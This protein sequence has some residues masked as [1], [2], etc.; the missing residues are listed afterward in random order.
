MY[1]VDNVLQIYVQWGTVVNPWQKPPER[2]KTLT[3]NEMKDKVNWYLDELVGELEQQTGKLVSISTLWQ[4]LVYCEI[5]RKKLH[6]AAYKR[7]ELLRSTFI[8]KVERDYKPE[9]LI[10]IDEASKDKRSSNEF[11]SW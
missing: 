7:N 4:S 1:T 6:Q 3:Q 9:Q 8:A 2:H 11:I 5:S 10:F